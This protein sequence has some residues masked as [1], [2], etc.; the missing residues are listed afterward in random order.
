MHPHAPLGNEPEF[1]DPPRPPKWMLDALAALFVI[2]LTFA[3]E[4][5]LEYTP[6]SIVAITASVAVAAILPLRRRWPI[7][8]FAIVTAVFAAVAIFDRMINVGLEIGIVIAL[9][10]VGIRRDLRIVMIATAVAVVAAVLAVV[11]VTGSFFDPRVPQ[12]ILALA[13]AGA[14]G[15]GTRMHRG[16]ITAIKE[17]ALRAE[18]TREAE[19]SRRVT[20]ERLR[21]ARDLHDAVAHEISVISL[22]AGVASQTIEVDPE[23]AQRSLAAVRSASRAVLNEIG[24]LLELLRT[25]ESANDTAAIPPPETPQPGHDQLDPLIFRFEEAGLRVSLRIEGDLSTVPAATGRA[26][27]RIVQESL[28]NAYKH[29]AEHRA[30]ILLVVRDEQ[31]DVVVTN[32][33]NGSG[34]PP[35][36]ANVYP[37]IDTHAGRSFGIAGMRERAASVRGT[38]ATNLG[39]GGWQVTASLPIPAD[40]NS[41]EQKSGDMNA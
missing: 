33:V 38:L 20:E 23:Q 13:F 27:Y 26:T 5:S 17:R 10:G 32:P 39:P 4:P 1:R 41:A 30:H 34:P 9:F 3:Q 7:A 11:S 24:D 18:Q 2:G 15:D 40:D 8:I 22:N 29:G 35:E 25:S 21:I 14:V 28:T 16:Y 12:V 6:P 19:A 37:A 36:D 31:L